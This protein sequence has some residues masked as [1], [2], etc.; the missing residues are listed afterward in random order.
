VP[1]VEKLTVLVLGGDCGG[2]KETIRREIIDLCR[3]VE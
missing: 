1:G 3:S 2:G